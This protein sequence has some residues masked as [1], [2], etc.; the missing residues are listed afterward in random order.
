MRLRNVD[1]DVADGAAAAEFLRHPWGLTDAG[2]SGN[3]TYLRGTA[4]HAYIVGLTQAGGNALVAATFSGSRAE[5][6]AL[7]ARVKKSG[8]RHT[9]WVAEYDEPGHGGGFTVEGPEKEPFRFVT[10]RDSTP[11]LAADAGRPLQLSHV[12]FNSLDREAGSRTLVDIFGFRLSDRTRNMNFVRCDSTHHA[13]ALAD[14]KVASL[15]HIAFE[16]T[17]LEAVL[18]GTGRLMDAGIASA[19]G[20]GRHGPG[21]NVFAYFIAPF[22]ACIEYTAEVQRVDDSYP[23]GAPED[24]QWPPNRNDHWGIAKRDNAQLAESGN[25]FFFRPLTA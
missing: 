3:T 2:A 1:L 15:N 9:S 8:L 11:S 10:E 14:A 19:W 5:V 21:N 17:D 12:V 16:M 4:D 22:G 24:W 23:T 13:V 6:E 7:Y 18:C 25:K 20:P